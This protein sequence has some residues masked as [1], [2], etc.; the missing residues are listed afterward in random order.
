M[1]S[2]RDLLRLLA[3]VP[4]LRLPAWHLGAPS[5]APSVRPFPLGQVRLGAGEWADALNVNRAYLLS[6]DPDRLLY[7]FRI[8]AGI[9]TSARPYGGWEAPDN[10]LRGHFVGHYLSACALLA[11]RTGEPEVAAR[12]ALMVTQLAACQ[13]ANGGGYLSAFPVAFFDRLRASGRVWAPFYTWHK[14]M[15]GM[16]DCYTLLGDR[17]ALGVAEG[18]AG[19]TERWMAGL[20]A[21]AQQK[22]LNVE[23]GGMVATLYDLGSATGKPEYCALGDQFRQQRILAPMAA[24]RDE[25]AGVHGN[26]TIPKVIG[27]GCRYE[28]TGDPESRAICEYFWAEVALHR[29]Y[30]TGGTTSGEGWVGRPDELAAS[31]SQ[32]TEETCV[33]YNMLKLTRQLFGWSPEPRYADFYERLLLNGILGTQHPA[34]GQKLYYTPLASGYWRLFGT[35]GQD[36][37]CCSGTGVENFAK[38]GD[39]IYFHDDAGLWVNLFIPSELRWPERGLTLTQ[40]TGFP[41]LDQ[42]TLTV[43]AATP[44]RLALRL[45]I[46]YWSAGAAVAVNGRPVEG[47][48][49][50][51]SYTVL[52]RTWR[53]GDRVELRLPMALHAA[54][55]PDDPSLLAIMYG[56]LVLAGRMGTAGI[57]DANRRAGPTAPY[58]VPE[59]RDPDLPPAPV[60]RGDAG[61]LAGW[62]LPTARPLEFQT[63][64]QD[65]NYTLVPFARVFDERYAVYWTI[66]PA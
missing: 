64:G 50:P 2:R 39:S 27:E 35:P 56:P 34:D 23:H 42:V 36:F 32:E 9:P 20:D 25:L 24:G 17:T 54:P 28:A 49:E 26:T 66:R 22:M 5:A 18:M 7:S 46:P 52:D 33:S 4:L 31:L 21:A 43:Q 10:E 60:L 59:F 15:A 1:V 57:S 61:N 6:L 47:P 53:T 63:T 51:S 11:S 19:W 62:I 8:V 65:L 40:E 12:G 29:S 30:A 55:M 48:H 41:E 58:T 45:R 13:Q 37:W 44:V 3:A 14:L 38:A 16:L